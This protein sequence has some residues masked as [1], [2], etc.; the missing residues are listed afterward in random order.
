MTRHRSPSLTLDDIFNL[1][2]SKASN[3]RTADT[4]SKTD[5]HY[6][7]DNE[8]MTDW[9]LI[10][11]DK[12]LHW[13]PCLRAFDE[14]LCALLTVTLDYNR[15]LD[16]SASLAR[17]SPKVHI[18]LVML[19]AKNHGESETFPS[20]PCLLTRWSWGSETSFDLLAGRAHQ[21][22]AGADIDIMGFFLG[23]LVLRHHGPTAVRMCLVMW[24]PSL[25]TKHEH[26]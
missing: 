16:R 21:E 26:R 23:E 18:D 11:P 10:E 13:V 6:A 2:T 9:D 19:A 24:T 12:H 14:F 5:F 1:V 20:P 3:D 17:P 25:G 22:I 4:S 15:S 7:S 8:L